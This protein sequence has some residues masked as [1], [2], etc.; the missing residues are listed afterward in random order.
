MNEHLAPASEERAALL[1]SQP[2][3]AEMAE[4]AKIG[5]LPQRGLDRLVQT[6]VRAV[7]SGRRGDG[8]VFVLPVERAV[9]IRSG[10]EGPEA[11]RT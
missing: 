2:V 6:I 9:K 7:R 5:R 11:L 8:L 4:V 1:P 3:L 10:Q